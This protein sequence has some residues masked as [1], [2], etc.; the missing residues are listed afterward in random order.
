MT[1]KSNTHDDQN[2]RGLP[3]PGHHGQ[4]SQQTQTKLL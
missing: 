4:G 1:R 3:G 2:A